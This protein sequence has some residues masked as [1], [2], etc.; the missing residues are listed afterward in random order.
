MT[1]KRRPRM[2]LAQYYFTYGA[3]SYKD[4]SSDALDRALV[5]ALEWDEKFF[6]PARHPGISI[7]EAQLGSI[8]WAIELYEIPK[9][10]RTRRR[11]TVTAGTG[12]APLQWVSPATTSDLQFGKE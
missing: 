1:G 3:E 10:L 6:R 8:L 5:A 4:W 9:H 12:Y 7:V 11:R 2:T